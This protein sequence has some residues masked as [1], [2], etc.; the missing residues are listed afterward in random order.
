MESTAGCQEPAPSRTPKS[1]CFPSTPPHGNSI[2]A[3]TC[4]LYIFLLYFLWRG[5]G[6][7]GIGGG[8]HIPPPPGLSEIK[9]CSWRGRSFWSSMDGVRKSLPALGFTVGMAAPFPGNSSCLGAR[10]GGRGGGGSKGAEKGLEAAREERK[11]ERGFF[12]LHEGAEMNY[13]SPKLGRWG[14]I[15]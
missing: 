1:L 8:W 10:R 6:G 11:R 12:S 3:N 15:D 7:E 5:L 2:P 13:L 4:S 9:G 14:I